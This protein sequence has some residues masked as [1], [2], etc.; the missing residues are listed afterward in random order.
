MLASLLLDQLLMLLLM[1]DL[2]LPLL[3][4]VAAL[5]AT[6]LLLL[7]LP[8]SGSV[9]AAYWRCSIPAYELMTS[10]RPVAWHA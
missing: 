1:L 5:L 9:P 4:L 7:P 2:A 6:L 10:S 8:A 3:L